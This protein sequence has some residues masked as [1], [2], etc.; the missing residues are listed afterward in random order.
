MILV[1]VILPCYT[2]FLLHSSVL[3][4]LKLPVVSS[5][6][7]QVSYECYIFPNQYTDDNIGQLP[8]INKQSQL[9]IFHAHTIHNKQIQQLLNSFTLA[10]AQT[11]PHID[12][13][14]LFTVPT[15]Q[16]VPYNSTFSIYLSIHFI[17]YLFQ[18]DSL[19]PNFLHWFLLRSNI[20]LSKLSLPLRGWVISIKR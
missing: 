11:P 3:Q 4:L 17:V 15:I 9:F 14:A 10:P 6:R 19:Q 16:S 5:A 18:I 1:P 20:F 7:F 13:F 12:G 2:T 8:F